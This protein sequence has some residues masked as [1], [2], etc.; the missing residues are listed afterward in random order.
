MIYLDPHGNRLEKLRPVPPL[1]CYRNLDTGEV[2]YL[3]ASEVNA[4]RKE[5]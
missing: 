1:I 3:N 2:V 4:L 5:T